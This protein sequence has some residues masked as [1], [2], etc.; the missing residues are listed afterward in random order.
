MKKQCK[1]LILFILVPIFG[2][3]IDNDF[4]HSKEKNI[5]K[6]YY[7]N[8]DATL[9]ID[10]SYGTISVTTWNEDK[11]ELGISIKV[12]GDNENWVNQRIE[13]IAVD[14]IAL[15]GMISA[16]TILGNSSFKGQGKNN[17]FEI[18]YMLKIP[19]NGSVKLNN[20]YGNINTT[21][22][23]AEADI[24]CK[25][26]KL[27]LGRLSG[28][29]TIQ[30]EYCNNSSIEFLKNGMVTAKYSNLK[31][32]ETTKLDLISDYTDIEIEQ[33][34]AIK[35][36]SKYGK[37]RIQNVKTLDATGNY[38][39]IKI[40]EVFDYLKLNTKY[41]SLAV[42]SINAKANSVTVVAGYT[43]INIGYATN[44]AFD[45]NV[46]LKYATFKYDSDLEIDSKEEVSNSKKYSGFHKKKG[47][48]NLSIISDYGNVTL[49]K[50][51]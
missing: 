24:K 11:I 35:Y 23:F 15:K 17:S 30:M 3:A 42:Q 51:Q 38:L 34:D 45:F 39:T 40:G 47:L 49:T 26:G 43:G 16:K 9:S 33:S 4:L 50:N 28:N 10:N 7:V 14:I 37:I 1:I 8:P 41:S 5:K 22:L 48:N 36:N 2:Y 27:T 13:T 44:F 18:N 29:S 20:K 46:L 25:Y 32:S 12:S 31:I 19:R 6:A 21:D